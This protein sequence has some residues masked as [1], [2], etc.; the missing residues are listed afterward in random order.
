MIDFEDMLYEQCLL[1]SLDLDPLCAVAL[2]HPVTLSWL[3][4]HM[5]N[6]ALWCLTDRTLA[7]EFNVSDMWPMLLPAVQCL[8]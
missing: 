8:Y 7:P 1:V 6:K 3:Y 5:F 4:L 2:A